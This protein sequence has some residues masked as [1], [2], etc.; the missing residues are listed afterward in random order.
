VNLYWGHWRLY[1]A[2]AL[3]GSAM[4]AVNWGTAAGNRMGVKALAFDVFGTVVDWRGSIIREGQEWGRAKGLQVDW[5]K[6]ADR[7]ISGQFYINFTSGRLSE[8][9]SWV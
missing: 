5:A 4:T 1:V 7:S 9:A 8:E 3:R 6:F 2:A